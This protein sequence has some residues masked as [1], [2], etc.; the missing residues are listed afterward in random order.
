[1]TSF[2][3]V[4]QFASGIFLICGASILWWLHTRESNERRILVL[5]AISTR[6]RANHDDIAAEFRFDPIL[7]T[8]RGQ[9]MN[10]GEV[11]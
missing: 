5:N 3:N 8:A 2:W 9:L 1:M 6:V 10:P 4:S 11:A 7:D